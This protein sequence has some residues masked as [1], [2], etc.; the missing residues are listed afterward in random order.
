[1]NECIDED[2]DDDDDEDDD[3]DND[4]EVVDDDGIDVRKSFKVEAWGVNVICDD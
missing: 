2:D 4:D 1:M 3:N